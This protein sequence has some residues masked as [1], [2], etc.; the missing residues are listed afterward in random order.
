VSASAWLWV[1]AVAAAVIVGAGYWVLRVLATPC[2][3]C[4]RAFCACTGGEL[5][6]LPQPLPLL[7]GDAQA[8][9][10]ATQAALVRDFAA[11]D[12]AGYIERAQWPDRTPAV[13]ELPLPTNATPGGAA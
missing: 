7:A 11:S 10:V 12:A 8:D 2:A 1:L 5:P 6:S 13:T 9:M 4:D 3:A